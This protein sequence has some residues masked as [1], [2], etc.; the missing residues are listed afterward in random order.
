[1]GVEDTAK[2]PVVV[3]GGSRVMI[4]RGGRKKLLEVLHETHMGEGS[5]IATARRVWW[6]PSMSNE[7]RQLYRNCQVCM[8]ESRVKQRQPPV[9]PDNLLKLGVFELVGVDLMQVANNMYLVLVNKKDR[10]LLM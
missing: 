6:W 2:G 7:I 4:P 3:I 9:I 10:L 5:M 1:M 8:L